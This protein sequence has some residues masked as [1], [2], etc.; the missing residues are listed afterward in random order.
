MKKK[1]ILKGILQAEIKI[2]ANSLHEHTQHTSNCKHV[3]RFR[4]P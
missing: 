4:I 2:K 3:V 1:E